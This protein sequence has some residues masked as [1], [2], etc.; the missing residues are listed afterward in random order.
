M[1]LY[2]AQPKTLQLVYLTR[3]LTQLTILSL[4]TALNKSFFYYKLFAISILSSYN[5]LKPITDFLANSTYLKTP[6]L[7]ALLSTSLY[8]IIPS[9]KYTMVLF[10]EEKKA[11]DG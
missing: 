7:T 5:L 11:G 4:A 2:I 10:L 3:Y 8:T 6:Y 9:T 1:C